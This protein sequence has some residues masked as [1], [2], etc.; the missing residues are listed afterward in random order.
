MTHIENEI[1]ALKESVLEMWSL[2]LSQC[3]KSEKALE[4]FDKDQARDILSNEKR[5]DAYE[6][7]INMDCERILA[8]F[9]PV[10][11]DLRFILSVIRINNELERIGDYARSLAK[12]VKE[13]SH[14]ISSDEINE[15]KILIMASKASNMIQNAYQS[16]ESET[17]E[18][19]R[20]I[21]KNDEELDEISKKSA[22]TIKK[23]IQAN[24]QE[25][26]KYLQ[27]FSAIHRIERM[28]DQAKSIAEEIV[29]YLEAKVIRHQKK[30]DKN[31]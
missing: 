6:L 16:F 1:K 19:I 15:L 23:L 11:N 27:L 8:L 24:P 26:E 17:I 7:K 31:L 14:A 18:P 29:F 21:F 9:N 22:T 30:K 20:Q 13:I 5:V 25:V 28:G 4:N 2:V 3:Y 10:A 12:L